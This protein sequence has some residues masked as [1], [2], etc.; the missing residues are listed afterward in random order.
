MALSSDGPP[1][2]ERERAAEPPSLYG[3]ARRLDMQTLSTKGCEPEISGKETGEKKKLK[4]KQKEIS[5]SPELERARGKTETVS[6]T[7]QRTRMFQTQK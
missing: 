6:L 4:E 1:G 2:A 5:G 7:P 3:N